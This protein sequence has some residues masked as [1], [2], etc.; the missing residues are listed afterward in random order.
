MNSVL[1]LLK[2]D[3]T[4]FKNNNLTK[5]KVVYLIFE[6][7]FFIGFSFLISLILA[8]V[9][10]QAST[11]QTVINFLSLI[12]FI[13]QIVLF[14][15]SLSLIL[16]K[17]LLSTD[18][19]F[20]VR[21]P[22]SRWKIYIAKSLTCLLKVFILN[23][24]LSIPFLLSFGL[25]FNFQI[26]YYLLSIVSIIFLPLIPYSL[27]SL[28]AVPFMAVQNF[29]KNK[30]LLKLIINICITLSLFYFYSKLIFTMADFIFLEK[31]GSGDILVD[32]ANVFSSNFF[33]SKWLAE[34]LLVSKKALF[35]V[36]FFILSTV[37]FI[38][39]QL[40]C[41]LSYNKIFIKSI[42]E[43]TNAKIIRTSNKKRS[44]FKSYF[45][46]EFKY[47]FRSS[48]YSYTYF[49]MALSMPIMILI[50]NKFIVNFAIERVGSSIVF[51]TT[52]LVVLVFISIIC[53]PSASF[54]SKEGNNYWIL[55]T[56][57]CGIKT[58]LFA[59]SLVG[60]LSSLVALICTSFVLV[61][62]KFITIGQTLIILTISILYLLGLISF[63]LLTNL[64]RPN[65]FKNGV[66]NN[67]NTIILM[68]ISFSL[69]IFFGII[70]IIQSLNAS[71]NNAIIFATCGV[72]LFSIVSISSLLLL[73]P[74]LYRRLEV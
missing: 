11:S 8:S 6:C 47:L 58:P 4:M 20:L 59:K 2:L 12:I 62:G 15:Y 16:K 73:Y 26:S 51:G 72:L 1:A 55:K 18:K 52:L 46:A 65:L 38:I 32:I 5:K 40:L 35:Y 56:N 44:A 68:V 21:L 23:L 49:V 13:I 42:V 67:S 57:P 19:S 48:T 25:S 53:S 50:C 27:A 45:V 70:T 66:E 36:L 41:S 74:K 54:L 9:F 7:I 37:L 30:S 24:M 69:S 61:F 34:I 39:S 33:P 64:I 28:I 60:V 43:K 31:S 22:I 17:L 10:K 71:L 29:L 63:G 3:Y 14:F